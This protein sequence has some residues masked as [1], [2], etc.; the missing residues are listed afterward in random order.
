MNILFVSPSYNPLDGTGWGSVQRTNLLF[1]ACTQLG[2][3]DV[4]T[5][6]DNVVSSRE[7]CSVL[8]AKSD[9]EIHYKEGRVQKLLRMFAPWNPYTMFPKNAHRVAIVRQFVQKKSYDLIVCRYIPSAMECG[10]FDFADKL[11]IDVDDN[12]SDVEK[13]AARTSRTLR[14]R[15]YHQYRAVVI[16]NV[17]SKIQ[18]KCHFTFFANPA[19]AIFKN[20][21]Y[22]PNIP[23]YDY[24]MKVVDFSKTT[25]RILFVGN[26]SYGPNSAGVLHFIKYIFPLIQK[27]IPDAELHLVGGCNNESFLSQCRAI[28]GVQYMGFVDSLEDEYS[29][30]RVVAVPIYGGAGTNIKVLEA[31]KMCRPCVTTIY[32]VRGFLD[33]FQHEQDIFVADDD[34]LFASAIIDMLRDETKN[35]SMSICANTA[36]TEHFSRESFNNIVKNNLAL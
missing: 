5:F 3:V 30:A 22:L 23:F 9:N 33:Y 25:N 36:V 34:A 13:T 27:E 2:H 21:A 31:M 4:I 16:G 19:Q 11:V 17:L 32:G 29:Q 6:V 35:H 20:S 14:N 8:Y 26:M 18:N 7:D 10:L 24:D 1:E 28:K 15:L 12:P